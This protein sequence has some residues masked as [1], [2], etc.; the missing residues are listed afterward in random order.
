M[1]TLQW[2]TP[3]RYRL[4]VATLAAVIIMAII[5]LIKI[6]PIIHAWKTQA[7][8]GVVAVVTF[9]LTLICAPHLDKGILAEVGLFLFLWHRLRPPFRRALAIPGRHHARHRGPS[10]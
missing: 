9:V 6:K 1:A 5:E 3:P 2:L 8:D 7:H 10:A 4:T